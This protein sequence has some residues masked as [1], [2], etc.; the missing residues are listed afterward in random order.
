M[1]HVSKISLI[2]KELHHL[3][4]GELLKLKQEINKLVEQKL[5][6]MTK[7]SITK[8][9]LPSLSTGTLIGSQIAFIPQPVYSYEDIRQ[10]VKPENGQDNSLGKIKEL[11]DEWMNDESG[12]DE[13]MY[14]QIEE[15]LN[16]S[17]IYF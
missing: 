3:S 2:T 8:P 15:G 1:S 6:E 14:P 9:S 10:L 12:D 13:V 11:I 17:Q 7:S 16:Q 5:S 4:L